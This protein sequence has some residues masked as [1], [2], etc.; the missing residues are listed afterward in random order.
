M[1][2]GVGRVGGGGAG[3]HGCGGACVMGAR[4]VLRHAVM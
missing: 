3:S 4:L 2:A 1:R